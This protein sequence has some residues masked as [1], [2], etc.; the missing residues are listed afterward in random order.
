MGE[1]REKWDAEAA[2][3]RT[4]AAEILSRSRWWADGQRREQASTLAELEDQF[5]QGNAAV[6]ATDLAGTVTHWNVA[7]E[8]LDGWSAAQAVGRTITDLL[9]GPEDRELAEEIMD[10]VRR[11]GHWEGKLDVRRKDGTTV[12]AR[13]R[14][15]IIENDD[16]RAVGL[17]GVSVAV[18]KRA[19]PP[20]SNSPSREIGAVPLG[21]S[22]TSRGGN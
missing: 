18:S 6:I 2:E 9:V 19:R 14:D 7:A 1:K 10:C 15:T 20:A 4:E 5:E 8:R 21:S 11:R 12:L 17:L 16:G 13:V 3:L 22:P